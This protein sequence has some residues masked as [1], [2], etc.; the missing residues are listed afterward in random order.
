MS[1]EDEAF[2]VSARQKDRLIAD[3]A[4]LG[5]AMTELVATDPVTRSGA[6]S[7]AAREILRAQAQ[8]TQSTEEPTIELLAV[9]EDEKD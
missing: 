4:S 3:A 8:T 2:L 5:L 7:A 1:T 9:P 6:I